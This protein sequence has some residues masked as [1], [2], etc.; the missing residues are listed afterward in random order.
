[1]DLAGRSGER[2]ADDFPFL[3]HSREHG[4]VSKIT[5][6]FP[7]T[8]CA[9]VTCVHSGLTPS[10]SGLYEWFQYEP[11]LDAMIAPLLFSFA[12][13]H[14]RDG[15]LSEGVD[16]SI[17]FDRP[18]I[19]QRLAEQ[20]VESIYV[21]PE[22]FTPSPYNDVVCRGANGIAYKSLNDGLTKLRE[23][24]ASHNHHRRYVHFYYGNV[25]LAS[26]QS[27]PDSTHTAEVIQRLFKALDDQI[28]HRYQSRGDTLLC[29]VADHGMARITPDEAVYINEHVP[30]L[31]DALARDG[32]GNPLAP[33]GSPR[34]LFLHLPPDRVD[35]WVSK[36]GTALTQFARVFKTDTLIERGL[37][38][39]TPAADAFLNRVGNITVLPHDD[40]AVWWHE[41]GK[42]SVKHAG[43]HGGLS[44]CEMEIP[45]IAL[46]I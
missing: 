33:A 7:S 20:R 10:Q 37:F 11:T 19:H 42:F 22:A 6:L 26:H 43:E 17:Y 41:P 16:A 35:E 36:L 3:R 12:G 29:L 30:A 27:G 9:H 34:D 38:G 23:V 14:Q 21:T 39:P 18:T 13:E 44:G 5:S 4:I 28:L 24:M 1:M 2:V 32:R 40:T 46:R 31:T 25:D 8:T 15:L 45:F